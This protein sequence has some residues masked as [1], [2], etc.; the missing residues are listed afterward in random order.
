MNTRV[1]LAG[2]LFALLAS[3]AATWL[4]FL[5]KTAPRGEIDNAPCSVAE[6]PA[7][8]KSRTK[9]SADVAPAKVQPPPVDGPPETLEISL[10]VGGSDNAPRQGTVLFRLIDEE[11][12]ALCN[13]RYEVFQ[14]FSPVAG[15]RAV[16]TFED[17]RPLAD[18]AVF[19]VFGQVRPRGRTDADGRVRV[20]FRHTFLPLDESGPIGE[21]PF[22]VADGYQPVTPPGEVLLAIISRYWTPDQT[23]I[24]IRLRK[25]SRLGGRVFDFAGKPVGGATVM[26]FA[27]RDLPRAA[28]VERAGAHYLFAD[29]VQGFCT[30]P[31]Q[32]VR[33]K[34]R[35]ADLYAAHHEQATVEPPAT[36]DDRGTGLDWVF[37]DDCWPSHTVQT[38]DRGVFIFDLPA[39]KYFLAAVAPGARFATDTAS[40]EDAPVGVELRLNAP[41]GGAALRVTLTWADA[42]PPPVDLSY[43]VQLEYH[44]ATPVIQFVSTGFCTI[45]ANGCTN[46]V[47]QYSGLPEGEFTMVAE[48]CYNIGQQSFMDDP[49][50]VSPQILTLSAARGA[51]ATLVFGQSQ[52]T[53]L[54]VQTRFNGKLL[55]QTVVELRRIEDE[56]SEEFYFGQ[57]EDENGK[58]QPEFVEFRA[59]EYELVGAGAPPRRLLLARGEQRKETLD[60]PSCTLD[61]SISPEFRELLWPSDSGLV[62]PMWVDISP[63]GDDEPLAHFGLVRQLGIDEVMAGVD[64]PPDS[65]TSIPLG[66]TAQRIVL[67]QGVFNW[68]LSGLFGGCFDL[69]GRTQYSLQLGLD[70]VPGFASATLRV[71]G[72]DEAE[73]HI[74]LEAAELQQALTDGAGWPE[75]TSGEY[76]PWRGQPLVFEGRDANSFVVFAPRGRYY[77]R[78]QYV[79]RGDVAEEGYLAPFYFDVPGKHVIDARVAGQTRK[80]RVINVAGS[81]YTTAIVYA[82]RSGFEGGLEPLEGGD[83]EL[84][85][86]ARAR[87]FTVPADEITFTI[88]RVHYE[89]RLVGEGDEQRNIEFEAHDFGLKTFPSGT[90]EIVL[91][92]RQVAFQA[93]A[94]VSVA[95]RGSC[96]AGAVL[97]RWWDL[98]EPL[99]FVRVLE[100]RFLPTG[101]AFSAQLKGSSETPPTRR[102]DSFFLPPGRFKVQPWPGA[103]DSACKVV[104]ILAGRDE[105]IVFEGK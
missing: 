99:V 26:A 58:L 89:M 27:V 103:P 51:E 76:D 62:F 95:V 60:W 105:K 81:A 68:G 41:G 94:E 46:C 20:P 14:I 59:G 49:A 19:S 16:P 97:D 15:L 7:T 83:D 84:E 52:R 4:L 82:T 69:R 61:V 67:P 101:T 78:V 71:E 75:V 29:A 38:D 54:N 56:Q 36:L 28:L 21:D 74:E 53:R 42:G 44:S 17:A 98:A 47:M 13:A 25:Q 85:E 30:S 24:E 39:G 2:L 10:P 73:C 33:I 50:F 87:E 104:E 43:L 22:P 8:P 12:G 57:V 80:L 100:C 86:G 45:V 70:T 88:A 34:E 9:S 102:T 64:W 3:L 11:T 32:V 31:E 93:A 72:L 79:G 77:A 48:A 55:D 23:P 35:L 91:D 37:F 40:L 5:R 66:E 96:P 1:I 63:T 6:T 90:D 65:P 92:L 18:Q